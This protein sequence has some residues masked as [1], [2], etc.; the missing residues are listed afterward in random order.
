MQTVRIKLS[1]KR[2]HN[3][4]EGETCVI[5][6]NGPSLD[7]HDLSAIPF[8]T[9]GTNASWMLHR[10][11]YHCLTDEWQLRHYADHNDIHGWTNLIT[12]NVDYEAAG[13]PAPKACIR[14]DVLDHGGE[15]QWSD[16][17]TRGVYICTTIMWVALQV[18]RYMG[19]T[20]IY[21]L[22]FDLC[23]HD[24]RS[25]FAAHPKATEHAFIEEIADI[26]NRLMG[27]ALKRLLG[28]AR[29]I[30]LFGDPRITQC[31]TLPCVAA[32]YVF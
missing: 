25:K 19:F 18:A 7:H 20:T 23:A 1:A 9:I 5:L 6:G 2:Y 16:D 29:I 10:S 13:I 4:H 26:Q 28:Q 14:L 12:A 32:R 21:L 31:D 17:L 22:G 30:N 27:W 8:P 24:G 3:K 15:A 11:T